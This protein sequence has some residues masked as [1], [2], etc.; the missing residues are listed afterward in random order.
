MRVF[1]SGAAAATALR[2][3]SMKSSFYKAALLLGLLSAVGPFAIDMYLP[4]L[5]AIGAQLH[6]DE[7][8]VQFSLMAFFLSLAVGQLG[9]GP[10]SDIAGRK[11]PLLLGLGL[12]VV[13][14]I[15]CALAP[16]IGTLVAFRFVQ[17]LGAG[18]PMAVPRAVVR[19]LHTGNDAARLMSLLMLVFS[20]SPILAPLAGSAVAAAAGWRGVFWA[21]GAIGLAGAVM[22][23]RLL[24]ETRGPAERSGSTVGSAL[25][26]YRLL[27]TDR[28]FMGLTFIGGFGM[29]SFFAYLANSSFVLIQHYGLSPAQYSVAFSINAVAFIGVSQITGWLGTR[30][31]LVRVVQGAVLGYLLAML[32]LL[33]AWLLGADSLWLLASLLFIGFGFL[34]LVVPATGV[35]SLDDHGEI[36]GTA[37]ALQ[38]TLQLLCGAAVMAVTGRF[39]DGTALPMVVAIGASAA[40]TALLTAGTLGRRSRHARVSAAA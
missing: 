22:S 30:F 2:R 14:S 10:A 37:A 38:G 25:R 1:T 7:S 29:A 3:P 35:L 33:A 15:G 39:I 13:G 27:L 24:P 40:A 21:V 26:A 11:R 31:G 32:A 34:G 8:A 18:A 19:D 4:V 6:A 28:P 20:V 16:D 12:F 9:W 17:G 23:L 5:P 36:A